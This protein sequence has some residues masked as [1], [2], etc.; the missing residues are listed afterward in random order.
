MS[1]IFNAT[2]TTASM[3]LTFNATSAASNQEKPNILW[4][5]I[6]DTSPWMSIY[7]DNTVKTPNIEKFAKKGVVFTQMHVTAPVCS[8]CRSALMVGAMQTTFGVHQHRSSYKGTEIYLPQNVK[9]LPEIFKENGY[10]TGCFGKKDYNF[11]YK[12]EDLYDYS[13][14]KMWSPKRNMTKIFA[15]EQPWFIQLQLKGGKYWN[16]QKVLGKN[17][18]DPRRITVPPQYPDIP[19]IRKDIAQHYAAIKMLDKELGEIIEQLKDSGTYD[20]TVIFFF[21]DHGCFLPRSKQFVYDE[22]TRVPMM[23]LTPAKLNLTKAGT[24]NKNLAS[25]IDISASSLHAAGIDIP[26]YFEGKSIFAKNYQNEFVVSARD[27]CDFTIENMRALNDGKYLYIRNFMPEKPYMQPQYRDTRPTF[28]K[29]HK[30]AAQG[31][32]TDVQL[33][34][35]K[36][37]PKPVEELYVISEDKNQIN[38]VANDSKYKDVMKLM[39]KRLA[40]WQRSTDDKGQYPES[41]RSLTPIYQLW[42]A[43]RHFKIKWSK[44][45]AP[46]INKTP[47]AQKLLN[48]KSIDYRVRIH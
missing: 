43:R 9:T 16:A 6:E 23:V 37:Q 36:L 46:F 47:E 25:S 8:A 33:K 19:E 14:S 5:E 24:F 27:R 38:N 10:K 30:L 18:V 17:S 40:D 22:G 12:M 48:D 13:E 45:Y 3:F 21:S 34:F 39:R 32:M 28:K 11:A 4:I 20:N 26:N 15:N 29:I 7:G 2:I 44:E 42:M 31:H 41:L 1:K 35:F